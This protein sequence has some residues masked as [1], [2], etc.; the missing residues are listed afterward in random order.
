MSCSCFFRSCWVSD[1]IWAD[2]VAKALCRIQ[3]PQHCQHGRRN[4][5]ALTATARRHCLRSQH[6]NA[7]EHLQR[8]MYTTPVLAIVGIGAFPQQNASMCEVDCCALPAGRDT[9]NPQMAASHLGHQRSSDPC[10]P[11]GG[12]S[13]HP[14]SAAPKTPPGKHHGCRAGAYDSWPYQRPVIFTSLGALEPR[15]VSD[16]WMDSNTPAISLLSLS[17]CQQTRHT[18]RP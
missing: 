16:G 1:G 11:H 3:G 12:S 8:S 15:S 6:D 5:Q 2:R 9:V 13:P 14:A 18:L 17:T 10:Q 4:C 7:H